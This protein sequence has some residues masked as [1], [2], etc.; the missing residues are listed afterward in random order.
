MI[1]YDNTIGQKYAVG[2][3]SLTYAFTVG[4]GANRALFVSVMLNGTNDY[5]TGVTYG[6]VA[7]TK[8]DSQVTATTY[9]HYV[10]V[11]AAPASGANNVV[12]STSASCNIFS[13]CVSYSGVDQTTPSE[14]NAKNQ[15]TGTSITVAV[16]TVT[17]NAWLY[18][19]ANCIGAPNICS[20]STNTTA[21]SIGGGFDYAISV[22]SNAAQTPVGSFSLRIA[23]SSSQG[24]GLIVCSVKPYS[25]PVS[26]FRDSGIMRGCMRGV[27]RP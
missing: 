25:D 18:G 27:C 11:L 8:V 13:S 5:V 22:D 7:M 15:T 4:V 21:R 3:T 2:A 20:A 16:T 9:I 6:G 24:L 1:A 23:S 19:G 14:A 12:V 17:N 10:Y 26:G